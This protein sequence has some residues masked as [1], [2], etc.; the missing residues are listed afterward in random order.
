MTRLWEKGLPL[1][2]R[3]LAFTAGED[4]LLDARLVAYDVLASTA[5]AEMLAEQNFI[6][7]EDCDAICSGLKKL[8]QEAAPQL[9]R[10][11]PV[12]VY[13]SSRT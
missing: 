3:V 7:G 1:A 2:E 9:Q 11:R 13:C 6:S 5:H 4:H 8:G 10:D 12:I